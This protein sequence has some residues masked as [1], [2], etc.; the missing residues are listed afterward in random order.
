MDLEGFVR[1][2]GQR[3]RGIALSAL[4][5]CH[6][7]LSCLLETLTPGM[8]HSIGIPAKVMS[9]IEVTLKIYNLIVLQE[10]EMTG[11]MSHIIPKLSHVS[12]PVGVLQFSMA[13]ELI[14]NKLTLVN[15]TRLE[16][17]GASSAHLALL[18]LA[19]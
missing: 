17:V 5:H 10:C 12:R 8:E 16:G 7:H 19:S 4:L 2:T 1:A 18:P 13:V 15:I 14:L 6:V 11:S 3:A 9:S